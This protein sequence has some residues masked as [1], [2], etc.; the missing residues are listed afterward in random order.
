MMKRKATDQGLTP[1]QTLVI[2][3]LA[4]GKT[5]TQ[6]ALETGIDRVTIYRWMSRDAVFIAEYRATIKELS[7]GVKA[8]IRELA[9]SATAT[10]KDLLANG[11][12]K[13]RLEVA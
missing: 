6:A 13:I 2:G 3:E 5:V 4:T 12:P 9:I 11:P 1:Q 10:L 7:D 8:A